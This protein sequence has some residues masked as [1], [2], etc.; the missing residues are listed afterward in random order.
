LQG[1]NSFFAAD[2]NSSP[3]ASDDRDSVTLFFETIKGQTIA[4]FK[5]RLFTTEK[6]S[7]LFS[8]SPSHFL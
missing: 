8:A 1:P 4:L 7:S 2:N 3:L 6:T 5:A